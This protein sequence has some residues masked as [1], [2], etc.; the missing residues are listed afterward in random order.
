MHVGRSIGIVVGLILAVLV[1]SVQFSQG[2]RQTSSPGKT[3]TITMLEPKE[4]YELIKKNKGNTNFVIIDIRTPEEFDSGYIEGA[5][6]INYYSATFVDDLHGL[7]KTK[8]YLVYCRTGRR[9][10]D[11]VSIMAR[12]GF[13]QIYRIKGDIIKWKSDRLPLLKKE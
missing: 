2:Q 10:A 6:N 13:G 4:A 11:A 7:D 3:T 1:V 9:T 8:T 5:V 12:Q